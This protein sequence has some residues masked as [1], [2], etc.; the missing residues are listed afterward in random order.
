MQNRDGEIEKEIEIEIDI[1][2]EIEKEG[3]NVPDINVGHNP[4]TPSNKDKKS[5]KPVKHKHGEY[6]NVLLTDEELEKLR[7]EYPD[8]EQR[9]ERLSEYIAS[10]GKTYKSHYATIRAWANRDKKSPRP[11]SGGRGKEIPDGMTIGPNGVLIDTTQRDD[12]P[13]G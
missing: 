13:W 5:S 8:L 3:E 2:I 12:L 6:K 7:A 4:P 11:Q 1:D 10:T 9:I